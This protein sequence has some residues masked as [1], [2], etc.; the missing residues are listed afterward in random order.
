[1][2][3]SNNSCTTER[4]ICRSFVELG[5]SNLSLADPDRTYTGVEG[6]HYLAKVAAARRTPNLPVAYSTETQAVKDFAFLSMYN[7][8]FS[9]SES[10]DRVYMS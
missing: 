10:P 4:Y 7:C 6:D 5:T 2:G 3:N 8:T 9:S 1:V